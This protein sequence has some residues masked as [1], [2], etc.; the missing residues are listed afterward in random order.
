MGRSLIA[1]GFFIVY[2]FKCIKQ[3]NVWLGADYNK[4]I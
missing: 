3:R 2:N 1:T 4:C